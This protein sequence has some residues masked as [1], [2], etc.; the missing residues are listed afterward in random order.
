[1]L[2]RAGLVSLVLLLASRVLGLL[3]ETALASAFG[4]TAAGDVAVLM[5]T[6]PDLVAGIFVSGALS[7]VL[8]PAWGQASA[9][10]VQGM[11]ARL[12]KG[13]LGLGFALALGV[14]L[15]SG[16][17]AQWLAAGAARALGLDVVRLA[18][19][20]STLSLPLALLA[21]LWTTRLQHAHD[22]LGM[23]AA[24]LVVNL[25]LIVAMSIIAAYA[26]FTTENGQFG[27]K[28]WVFLGMG[29]LLAGALRLAWLYWRLP[30]RVA[31]TAPAHSLPGPSVWL[32]AAM[33]AGLPL[34]LVLVARSSAAGAG[35]GALAIFNY[36]WKLIELPLVLAVQ[37][38]ATLAFAHVAQ[39]RGTARALAARRA[40]VLAWAL[41][42][43]A[44][45][46]VAGF[47]PALAQLL[48]GYGR[49]SAAGL[50]H[51]ADWAALGVWSLPA[52]AVIAVLLTVLATERSLRPVAVLYA[53]AT[54]ALLAAAALWPPSGR[55][56]MLQLTA[57][58]AL[59]GIGVAVL[60]RHSMRG[61]WPW[62]DMLAPLVVCALLVG[63]VRVAAPASGAWGMVAGLI[64]AALAAIIVLAAAYAASPTLR[65][66]QPTHRASQTND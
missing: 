35:E 21:A 39:A 25:V 44:C 22:A 26:V 18:L 9:A 66:M 32:W 5:L 50:A 31:A 11:Q 42:C 13:L 33:A 28:T 20:V 54:L 10:Q 14:A 23:Y 52:Q 40:L 36:A 37:L 46:A 51:I 27:S 12:A 6:L 17:L 7:Y 47:A 53:A 24:N 59:V 58:L 63:L 56:V 3:R 55:S 19:I 2:L 34:A 29:L 30:A 61:N 49:M 1:M 48:F 16:P 45:A 62:R 60:A 64:G 4:A 43:A 57:V 41:A 15:A 38:V 65:H 8:L